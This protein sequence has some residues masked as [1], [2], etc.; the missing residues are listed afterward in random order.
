MNHVISGRGVRYLL[1]GVVVGLTACDTEVTNP[2]PVQDQFLDRVEAHDALVNGMGRATAQALNWLSYTGG[3]VARELHPSGSTGSFGITIKWQRG[4]L[5]PTDDGLDTHWEQAQRARWLS[6]N[7]IKRMSENPETNQATL[8]QAHLWAGYANRILGEH[9]CSAVID[10]GAIQP[11]TEFLNRA[12]A[13]FSQASTLGTGNVRTA[14][15]AGR[16]AVRVQLGKW[17]D[18]VADAAQI[19]DGFAYRMPYFD[20]GNDDLRNRIQWAMAGTPYRAHTVWTTQWEQ[21]YK[22]TKDPRVAWKDSGRT[23]DAAID[24]C[25]LV[26]FYATQKYTGPASPIDLSTSEEM[27]LI[28]AE[29]ML[30]NGNVAG[31]MAKINALRTAAGA[32]TVTAATTDEAWTLLKRERGI[33]LYLEGRRFGD[34]RRWAADSADGGSLH[35]LEMPSGDAS[36]GSHLVK[37]DLCFPIPPT[38]QDTNPNVPNAT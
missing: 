28:E 20:V 17:T 14:A 15:I 27:R 25:G 24:C 30:R 12:E 7:G 9:M 21:Y 6:E 16:A 1:M 8:A 11:H 32:P 34:L 18:A 4:E 33:V 19:A 10:G 22:D 13:A 37:Q 26:P 35:P 38:E 29:A 2:G 5:S 31:A 36:V 3:A 23:G